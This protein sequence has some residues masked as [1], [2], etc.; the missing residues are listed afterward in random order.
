MEREEILRRNRAAHEKDEGE[1]YVEMKSRRYGEIGLCAF[2]I[3]MM[4]Y[5]LAKGLPANDLLA[6]I[7]GYLGVSFV[8]KYRLSGNKKFLTSAICG[9]IAAISFGIAYVFQTW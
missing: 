9:I 7:W 5:K 1:Q 3:L 2:F 8:S 6:V 4:V